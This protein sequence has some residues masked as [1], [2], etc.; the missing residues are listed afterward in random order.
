THDYRRVTEFRR[1]HR[2]RSGAGAPVA[3]SAEAVVSNTIQCGFE[4]HPGHSRDHDFG[5]TNESSSATLARRLTATQ[6]APDGRHST[7]TASQADMNSCRMSSDRL[8]KM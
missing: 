3:Q 2:Y 7:P 4:S 6:T 5:P 1:Q 8:V